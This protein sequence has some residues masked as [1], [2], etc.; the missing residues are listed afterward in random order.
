MIVEFSHVESPAT[1][2]LTPALGVTRLNL[3]VANHV[4]I[5]QK[6]WTLNEQCQAIGRIH[7]LGQK[8][9]PTA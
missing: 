2:V 9:E 6:F 7:H 8:R 1:L 3:V 5:L 4:V